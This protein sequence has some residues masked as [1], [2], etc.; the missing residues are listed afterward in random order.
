MNFTMEQWHQI[1]VVDKV[2]FGFV[3]LGIA[4]IILRIWQRGNGDK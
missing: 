1:L 3:G 4:A 2:L